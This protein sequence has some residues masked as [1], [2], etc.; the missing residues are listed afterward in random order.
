MMNTGTLRR[1]I[2]YTITGT[3]IRWTSNLPYAQI[4]NEGG[5]IKVTAKMKKFFWAKYKE[6]TGKVKKG[7]NG[8]PLKSSL[9]VS[10]VAEYYKAMALKKVGSIIE[11]PQRQ[12]IGFNSDTKKIVEDNIKEAMKPVID[13]IMRR[14]K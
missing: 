9:G 2:K 7:K 10:K 6:L 13:A 1:S 8:K 11:I 4:Q 12:F 5:K 14:K 3:T